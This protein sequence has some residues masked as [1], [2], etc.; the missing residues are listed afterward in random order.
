MKK[1]LLALC[2]L[3]ARPVIAQDIVLTR[4]IL[5]TLSSKTMWGRGY[6]N[7]GLAKA[8]DF[9][10]TTFQ[11]YGLKPLDG[12]SF[13]QPFSFPVNTFPGSM[14]LKINGKALVPGKDFIVMPQSIGKTA[15]G[16]LEQKDSTVFVA[17]NEGFVVLLKDKL[18]WSV[19]TQLADYT[20]IEVQKNA[21]GQPETIELDIAQHFITDF[22]ADNV[23]ALV[24]GTHKPDSLVVFTAHYDHLGG[25]GSNT[26]FPGAN[27]NASGVS[28]LLS[29]AK[30]YAAHPPAYSMAF[31]CFAGEEAGLLGSKYFTEHPPVELRKIR[32]LINLDMVGT[33][34]TGITVVNAP[35]HPREFTLLNTINDEHQYLAKINPRGKTANSDHYYFSEKGVP[36]FFIYTT[37]GIRAYHDVYDLPSTLPFTAYEDLFK[38]L[39]TFNQQLMK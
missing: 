13:K 7:N 28:F 5:D 36:A 21:I 35:L 34:E 6:T 22:K 14:N 16:K 24:K 12:T 39:T 29:M 20:G 27:D 11:A 8:A 30:H 31:I 3:I 37:G 23:C 4:N 9:I 1:C 19:S 38:L 10:S 26:Y 2:L 25:M 17:A 32:F 33:G 18:T 15:S